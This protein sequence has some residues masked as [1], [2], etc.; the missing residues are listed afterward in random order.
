MNLSPRLRNDHGRGALFGK[1]D[2][3][4]SQLGGLIAQA[5]GHH[6]AHLVQVFK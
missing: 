5:T 3:F 4:F 6:R 2:I 1:L